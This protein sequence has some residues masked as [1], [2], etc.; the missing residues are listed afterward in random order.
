MSQQRFKLLAERRVNNTI[1]QINMIGNLANKSLY[2]YTDD[3]VEKIFTALKR[4]LDAAKVKFKGR[5]TE[6]FKEFTL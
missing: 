1:K 4:E 6:V 3:K 5:P 2:G